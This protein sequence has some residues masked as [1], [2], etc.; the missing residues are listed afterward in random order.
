MYGCRAKPLMSARTA[1]ALDHA[2]RPTGV[3]APG[4]IT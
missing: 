4:D 3:D 1:A 2:S